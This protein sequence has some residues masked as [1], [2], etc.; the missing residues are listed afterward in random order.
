MSASTASLMTIRDLSL[1]CDQRLLCDRLNLTIDTGDCIAVLGPNG[2]GKTSLLHTLAGLQKIQRGEILLQRKHLTAWTR[3]ELAKKIG[4]LFQTSRD[5]MPATVMET[6]LLGRLPHQRG[7]QTTNAE[8]WR[9]CTDALEKMGLQALADQEISRLSGGERQRVAIA[10]LIAQ[11]PLVYLL[12]EP[13]NHLDVSF[14]IHTMEL[15]SQLAAAQ[16][17]A[18]IMATHDINLAAR[19]CDKVVLLCGQGHVV[20]GTLNEVMTEALL[21]EAFA[22]DI[23]CIHNDEQRWFYPA[24]IFRR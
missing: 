5:D 4:L 13:T 14:Q 11:S 2:S 9:I 24:G 3:T 1:S 19:F 12:D 23:R 21:S 20:T 22:F 16:Q 15:L 10:A 6:I 7:W 18:M 17:R 8:D